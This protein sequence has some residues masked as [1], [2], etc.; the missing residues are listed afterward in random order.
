MSNDTEDGDV[1]PS[2]SVSEVAKIFNVPTPA[3]EKDEPLP[4]TEEELKAWE[5]KHNNSLDIYKIA[6]R[7]KNLARISG[8]LTPV[9]EMMCNTYVHVLKA[10]YEFA[11]TLSS[12][13]KERLIKL[14]MRHEDMPANLIAASGINRGKK[15]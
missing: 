8:P 10:L 9:G 13:D 3:K 12:E 6:A 2:M 4:T 1:G 14:V 5:D 7:V 15:K 11:D